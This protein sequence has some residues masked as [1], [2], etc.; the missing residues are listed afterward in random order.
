MH[1][2]YCYKQVVTGGEANENHRQSVISLY[3]TE[4]G[5]RG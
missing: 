3:E 5:Y 4:I 2:P 1:Q